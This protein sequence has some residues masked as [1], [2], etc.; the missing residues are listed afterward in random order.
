ME[1]IRKIQCTIPAFE[2]QGTAVHGRYVF[3]TTQND[4]CYKIDEKY[5]ENFKE[6]VE[7]C[8]QKYFIEGVEIEPKESFYNHL[9]RL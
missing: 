6:A 7:N 3:C 8:L 9:V 2:F 4:Y 5:K 1:K